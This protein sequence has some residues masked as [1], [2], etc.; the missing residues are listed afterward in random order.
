MKSSIVF[1]IHFSTVYLQKKFMKRTLSLLTIGLMSHI[2]FGQTTMKQYTV[3]HPLYISIP[4]YMNRTMDLNDDAMFQFQ[5]EVKDVYGYVIEDNKEEL[6]IAQMNFSS[7]NEFYDKF[8]KSFVEGEE[9]VK[10]SP[11]VSQKKG[12]INFIEADVSFYSKEAKTEIYYFI[13]IV[14]T[15]TAYYKLLCYCSLENKA[16]FK[17]D[18]QKILY[19]L[20]D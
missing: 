17:A 5:S 12:D 3:G 19:S 16:K 2:A 8:I 14:E 9:T 10:Q 6:K 7:V 13:G 20:R 18:F 11:P 15:K 4:D 1:K